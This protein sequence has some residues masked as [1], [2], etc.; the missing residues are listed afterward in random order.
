[1][2]VAGAME[3]TKL[4]QLGSARSIQSSQGRVHA[5]LSNSHIGNSSL[6]LAVPHRVDDERVGHLRDTRQ[7]HLQGIRE[8]RSENRDDDAYCSSSC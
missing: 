6:L 7:K 4:E 5:L 8:K 3:Q 1:M 2:R